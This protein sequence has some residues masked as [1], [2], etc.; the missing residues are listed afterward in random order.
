[1]RFRIP[2]LVPLLA[3]AMALPL[4]SSS[5]PPLTD[6][7]KEDFLKTA[8]IISTR[9]LSQGITGSQRATLSDGVM[10]HD[11]HIQTID[12]YKS[13][14]ASALG[15][16]LNFRDT[17]RGNIA[18]YRLSRILLL[19]M[20]PPSVER[21]VGGKT[22]AV[23]W[24]IDDAAMTEKDRFQKKEDPPDK[25]R[26]NR[27]MH[28]VRL[29]DQLIYNMDRN[30]GNLVITKNWDVWMIDH[31]R[32]FRLQT[33]IKDPGNLQRCDRLLL[34]RLRKL[35]RDTVSHELSPC[36]SKAEINA[37]LARRDRIVK[38]FEELIAARG[39]DEV[40]YDFLANR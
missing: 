5:L 36:L 30:L 33:T 38:H 22:A 12:E 31:T 20:I 27:Q 19:N 14:F 32:A 34:E 21:K 29:F 25:D 40:L 37:I 15:T 7:Q 13:T 39:E 3:A 10:T 8:K 28:I 16:E 24:W 1:M 18:G 26:W 6:S 17:Y 4:A 2:L 11:A 9:A 23:T 35:D